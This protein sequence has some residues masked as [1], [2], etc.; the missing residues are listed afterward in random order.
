MTALSI[1]IVVI[2]YAFQESMKIFS[3]ELSESDV[4]FETNKAMGRMTRELKNGLEI[5]SAGAT[6]ISFWWKDLN[7]NGTREAAETVT[8]T[9]SGGTFEVLNRTQGS[10]TVIIANSI[11]GLSL[12]YDSVLPNTK[13]ITI[14]ITALK[15]TLLGTLESS[16]KCRNL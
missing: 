2:F 6:S 5:T 15:G 9:W 8:Y 4:Q 16:V 3:S 13:L 14:R 10:S 12:T 1:A 7:G 11:K